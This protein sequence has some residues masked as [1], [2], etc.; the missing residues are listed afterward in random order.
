MS[1]AQF[2]STLTRLGASQTGIARFLG[3]SARNVRRWAAGDS[4][5]PVAVGRLLTL[6]L[7]HGEKP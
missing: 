6:M 2:R 3:V 5:V 1:P 4:P 7:K